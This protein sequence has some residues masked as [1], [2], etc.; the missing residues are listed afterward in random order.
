MSPQQLQHAQKVAVVAVL[1]VPRI[2]EEKVNK[3]KYKNN[4]TSIQN[5]KQKSGG[6]GAKGEGGRRRNG[7]GDC[8]RRKLKK[9]GTKQAGNNS[10]S[11]FWS[12]KKKNFNG[13]QTVKKSK[14]NE[15]WREYIFDNFWKYI[16]FKSR[17]KMC[18]FIKN[19]FLLF[20][21]I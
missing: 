21:L 1:D 2:T 3:K 14:I 13:K 9:T 8:G 5:H 15:L 18:Y 20:L 17:L 7:I 19:D 12:L 4:Q 10:V 16:L 11:N 6:E